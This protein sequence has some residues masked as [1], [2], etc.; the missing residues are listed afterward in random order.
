MDGEADGF[1]LVGK[2]A[3]NGLLDPPAGVSAELNATTGQETID[4]FHQAEVALGDEVEDGQA[5]VVVI[6][7]KFHHEAKIGFDH[8]FAGMVFA[9]ADP[10]GEAEFL[11]PIQEGGFADAFKVGLQGGGEVFATREDLTISAGGFCCHTRL[12]RPRAG[13][14]GLFLQSFVSWKRGMRCSSCRI[15][16]RRSWGRERPL[17]FSIRVRAFSISASVQE[18]VVMGSVCGGGSKSTK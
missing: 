17:C 16:S 7:G 3:T 4:G 5:A 12:D 6:G 8:E 1:S 9:S 15:Q 18:G 11:L 10:A 14:F 13:T 2:G